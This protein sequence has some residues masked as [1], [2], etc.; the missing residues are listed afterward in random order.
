MTDFS[1][2]LQ[3][4][5]RNFDYFKD[6]VLVKIFG[7][8]D[9]SEA[10]DDYIRDNESLRKAADEANIKTI[11]KKGD[12][13]TLG[14]P[15]EVFEIVMNSNSK[16]SRSR[17]GIQQVIRRQL[18]EFGNAFMVF[19]YENPENRSWR[20][21]FLQK[22]ESQK[23]STT[24]KR[25]TY[26]FGRNYNPRTANER[27][28][29]LCGK[30][31]MYGDCLVTNE[32]LLD[33][34]S[35]EALTKEF[36]NKLFSWFLWATDKEKSLAY[37]PNMTDT[38][39][40]DFEHLEIHIIR[41]LTRIMFVWFI[42][43]KQLVSNDLFDENALKNILKDFDPLSC[44]SSNYYNAILQNLF[45]AT[46]NCEIAN[47]RF[48]HREGKR[49]VKRLFRYAEMFANQDEQEII[50]LFEKTPFL[51]GGLFECLD[52][53]TQMDGVKLNI[54]GFSRNDS[55]RSGRFTNRAFIA[56]DLFFEKDKGLL[57]IF[58]QYNFTIEDNSPLEQSVALDPELLGK[59]FENLLG[60]INPETQETVRKSTG[61]FYTPQEVVNY[62]VNESILQ[63]L[64]T[65]CKGLDTTKIGDILYN[66][67]TS[68]PY[69]QEETKQILYALY[70]CRILDPA[71]GSGAFP[72][73]ML[74][75]MVYLLSV[76]D[77]ENTLWKGTVE[78]KTEEEDN[79]QLSKIKKMTLAK[80]QQVY[81]NIRNDEER[82]KK[83]I[84]ID[85]EYIKLR[86]QI[87]KNFG[88]TLMDS[89]YWRKLYLI[90]N[91]IYGVDIQPIAMQISKLR[92]FISLIV[93]Q[94]TSDDQSN[95]YGIMP[96]PNLET[97]FVC[98]NTLIGRHNNKDTQ[99]QFESDKI[100]NLKEKISQIREKHFAIHDSTAKIKLREQDELLRAELEKELLD[101]GNYS[102]D[103][104]RK[105]AH[106]NP[107]DQNS[108]AEFFA[109]DFMFNVCNGFDIII[110]NPPYIR[111]TS[112]S[113]NLKTEYEKMY[114][115]AT[116]QYDIYL[117]FIERGLNL[118]TNGGVLCYIN[119]IRFFN[120][121]YGFG[122]RK[123]IIKQYRLIK[124]VDVSQL[125]VFENA[126]T[127][128][129][130]LVLQN[131]KCEDNVIAYQKPTELCQLKDLGTVTPVLTI[132]NE[133]SKDK[134][135]RFII[136][137]QQETRSII[138]KMDQCKTIEHYFKIA[139][140][141]ANNKID[142]D[143]NK[144]KALKS[145]N[146]KK[147][148]TEGDII[149]IGTEKQYYDL[150]S[151]EMIIMPRT[152]LYL[153]ATIKE[154]KII[155]LDRIYYLIP[156][157]KLNLKFVLGVINS[158]ITNHWFEFYYK[159]T[160]VSGNY[161]DLNG[162][163]IGSIP[164]PTATA[165]QQE[166]IIDLVEKILSAKKSNPKNDTSDLEGK[167]DHLVC[168]LYGLTKEEIMI[169]EQK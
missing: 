40:D 47:R 117:L 169:V 155:C 42:K 144:Y 89:N 156:S 37:F 3:S 61:S 62:M 116:N 100:R 92:F 26:V 88:N 18:Q 147:Y 87:A 32:D 14:T 76:L 164:I 68:N 150:F 2:I 97:K 71:C 34:F 145:K 56:N 101:L 91:C 25:Y 148:T 142:F 6:E 162:N 44:D 122:C 15:L 120:A 86:G 54:D 129:C 167:I 81:D 166:P 65:K 163:Q 60:E 103:D 98:A 94:T 160:K 66:K 51:N 141:L 104:A 28:N 23:D 137:I 78:K 158:K 135:Y 153:Q 21:S 67:L 85:N 106:W 126:M 138:K 19:R 140:G 139:R 79:A 108:S 105:I 111:R 10:E 77:P 36:Y 136:D 83:I 55:K 109:P 50:K 33:A 131:K 134:E 1:T 113:D 63:Y 151:A 115:S 123:L 30:V 80:F 152:V 8:F 35:V 154:P 41:F 29:K 95:N 93:S 27:F 161:F 82:Q 114:S 12:I 38:S 17:I 119:P 84:E 58:R 128:P 20:F 16:I 5:Y 165:A 96:L 127:Y 39:K 9:D 53:D 48:A 73:G 102:S 107:Y 64:T 52:K 110:G 45:F 112:L 124:V 75:Q 132:Q 118:A 72:M 11:S 24:A 70:G 46:L 168:E 49:D 146:V 133:L 90:Q 57:E 4:D 31:D 7:N 99:G 121:D 69:S 74:N 22:G 157:Q 143:A 43:Q 159:T 130:I 149:R 125:P 59:V 13:F